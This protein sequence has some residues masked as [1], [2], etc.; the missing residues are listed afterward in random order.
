MKLGVFSDVHADFEAIQLAV[1]RLTKEHRVDGIYCLGD[2]TDSGDKP[3]ETIAFLMQTKIS[4]IRGNHDRWS[5]SSG[6]ST[7]EGGV[8]TK[9][10]LEAKGFLLGLPMRLERTF[11]GI[12]IAFR[13]AAP[14]SDMDGFYPSTMKAEAAGRWLWATNST[15][16]L[17][18]HTHLPF[19]MPGTSPG[20]II[21][22]PGTLLR[23]KLPRHEGEYRGTFGIL[24][25]P[26]RV[27]RV[28]DV[29]TGAALDME[30]VN[31]RARQKPSPL[32]YL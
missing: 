26:A 21:C 7:S 10:S 8:E 6:K 14:R 30:E 4:C 16:L 28:Y 32:T 22:N 3:E 24:E 1:E 12:A 20:S 27:F 17:V 2:V 29:V 18:G 31:E 5:L 19:A 11:E 23:M 25:L 13:H 9:L 15:V